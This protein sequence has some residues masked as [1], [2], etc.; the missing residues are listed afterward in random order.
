MSY[1]DD[2]A[3]DWDNHCAEQERRMQK[4]PECADCGKRITDDFYYE[5]DGEILCEECLN[6]RHRKWVD[7]FDG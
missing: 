7:D 6:D 4:Y 1:T 2:P 3:R 5:I